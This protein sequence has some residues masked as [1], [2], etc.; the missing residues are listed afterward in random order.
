M[1]TM[2]SELDRRTLLQLGGAVAGSQLVPTETDSD[3][4]D[5]DE[6]SADEIPAPC[7]APPPLP[8]PGEDELPTLDDPTETGREVAQSRFPPEAVPDT[9]PIPDP[10]HQ[11]TAEREIVVPAWGFEAARWHLQRLLDREGDDSPDTPDELT[12]CRIE[13]ALMGYAQLRERFVT[14]D[15]RDA[16]DAL[17]VSLEEGTDDRR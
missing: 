16:V 9:G 13:E 12:E 14:P 8:E 5:P 6:T 17:L 3:G 15:G 1:R 4:G 10:S 7:D 2:V 11:H